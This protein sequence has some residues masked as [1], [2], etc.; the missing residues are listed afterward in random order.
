MSYNE[1][2]PKQKPQKHHYLISVIIAGVIMIIA[3]AFYAFSSFSSIQESITELE[4]MPNV[5]E[6]HY[7][8][9]QNSIFVTCDNGKELQ[10]E[11]EDT[12]YH[13]NPIVTNFCR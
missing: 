13:Y 8:G 5:A 2:R 6:A 1:A 7:E 11:L 9:D 3:I 12:I 10:V 4:K